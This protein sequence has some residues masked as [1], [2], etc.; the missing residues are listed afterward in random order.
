M[1]DG[2]KV[3]LLS[4]SSQ[5]VRED[6]LLSKQKEMKLGQEG[7]HRASISFDW[8][9]FHGIGK[10][11]IASEECGIANTYYEVALGV[12]RCVFKRVT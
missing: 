4:L 2:K 12:F 11:I 8:G 5:Q 6:Q 3:N 7:R 1:L 10:T 9:C